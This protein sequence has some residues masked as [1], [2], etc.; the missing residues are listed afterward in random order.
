VGS[1]EPLSESKAEDGS[2]MET[3]DTLAPLAAPI[4]AY[5]ATGIATDEANGETPAPP[6]TVA[7]AISG[8]PGSSR[9]P[10]VHDIHG[11]ESEASAD[12]DDFGSCQ[13]MTDAATQ[14]LAHL[15]TAHDTLADQVDHI[16][17]SVNQL[18]ASQASLSDGLVKVDQGLAAAAMS[19]QHDRDTT[20]QTLQLI[21]Q[22]LQHGKAPS[23][24]SANLG[25][26]T[27]QDTYLEAPTD[28]PAAAATGSDPEASPPAYGPSGSDA[29][30]PSPDDLIKGTGKGK[31]DTGRPA[32]Y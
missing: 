28:P 13:G 16:Q 29:A 4:A 24:A 3:E 6:G 17:D 10:E 15:E 32:P 30:W 2:A 19:Q 9:T 11:S 5:D 18:L 25:I 22:Q 31:D 26:K 27:E 8:M 7:P 23:P 20:N 12:R 1:S 14:R 21:L